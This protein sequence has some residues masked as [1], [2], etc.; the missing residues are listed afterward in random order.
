MI[1]Q[2]AVASEHIICFSVVNYSPV[3]IQFGTGWIQKNPTSQFVAELY[4]FINK[5]KKI[6]YHKEIWDKK[7]W[8]LFGAFRGLF[9]TVQR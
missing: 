7:E 3:S 1:K 8:F 6:Y 5:L 2:N 4:Q 9:Q